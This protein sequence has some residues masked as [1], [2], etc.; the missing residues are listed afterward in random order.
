[1]SESN[2]HI[3]QINIAQ[4]RYPLDDPH[5]ID[6][7]NNLD[8]IN[9]LAESYPGFI[10]RL[11]DDTGNATAIQIFDDPLLIVNMSVWKSLG[12]LFDFTY[13]SDHI[14]VFR[15][16][17][18]WFEKHKLDHLALWWVQSGL[19]PSVDEGK[20][21]LNYIKENGPSPYAFNFKKQFSIQEFKIYNLNRY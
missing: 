6:F 7:V 13:R 20:K 15:R 18:E 2:Y 8:R 11:K 19:I 21:K 12:T 9:S 16:S 5:T 10:W 1:M 14:D 3:A 4:L 17:S